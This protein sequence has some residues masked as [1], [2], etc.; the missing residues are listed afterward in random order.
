MVAA[1]IFCPQKLRINYLITHG[2][3]TYGGS[4]VK[5]VIFKFQP[6]TPSKCLL[7]IG[8][9]HYQTLLLGH[10]YKQHQYLHGT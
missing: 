5:T 10:H 3:V 9:N 4:G 2:Q 6:C 1:M 7:I 8:L